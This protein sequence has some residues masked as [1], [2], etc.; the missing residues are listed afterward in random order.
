M[1][2]LKACFI[3]FLVLGGSNFCYSQ[4]NNCKKDVTAAFEKA[5]GKLNQLPGTHM[6]SFQYKMTY[7]H[8][9]L[10]DPQFELVEI[11]K[12]GRRTFYQTKEMQV[13]QDEEML[14]TVIPSQQIAYLSQAGNKSTLDDIQKSLQASLDLLENANIQKCF[15]DKKGSTQLETKPLDI[16]EV[17]K[18]IYKISEGQILES[19][20][21]FYAG[22]SP[23]SRIIYEILALETSASGEPYARTVKHQA[24]KYHTASTGFKFIDLTK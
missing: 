7:Y 1:N 6:V 24:E 19:V 21:V 11:L 17:E 10:E 12:K 14:L 18:V 22:A 15:L 16:K 5:Y 20:E 4:D 9:D 23:Y 2:M 3:V 13:Y 8:K